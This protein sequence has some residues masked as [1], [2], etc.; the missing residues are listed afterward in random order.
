MVFDPVTVAPEP[1][2]TVDDLPAG[3]GRLFA[4]SIGIDLVLCNGVEVVRDG[5]M[6]DAPAG[7]LLRGGRDTH[8]RMGECS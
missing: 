5:Q 1:V 3:A 6:T 2:R 4:G 7:T 8:D